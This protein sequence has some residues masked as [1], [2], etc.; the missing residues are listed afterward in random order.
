MWLL[1]LFQ[2]FSMQK[3]AKTE[4]HNTIIIEE[5]PQNK[6]YRIVTNYIVNKKAKT[7]HEHQIL[8]NH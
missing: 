7:R 4:S 5:N 8:N 3:I 2:V 6:V 1:Y